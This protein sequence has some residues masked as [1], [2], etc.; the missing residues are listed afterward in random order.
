MKTWWNT[1]GRQDP[2]V[3]TGTRT[4]AWPL[5]LLAAVLLVAL[6]A[7]PARAADPPAQHTLGAAH[8]ERLTFN[9]HW[10][11]VPAG[12]GT[13]AFDR[14][15]EQDFVLTATL[16]SAGAVDLFFKVEDVVTARGVVDARGLS[17]RHYLKTQLEGRLRRRSECTFDRQADRVTCQVNQEA[18]EIIEGIAG[19][20]NDPITTLYLIRAHLDFAPGATL[21]IPLLDGKKWYMARV[22][23]G[24]PERKFTPLGWFDVIPVHPQLKTSQLFRHRGGITVWLTNDDRR[25]PVRVETKVR[26]GAVAAD[27]VGYADGRGGRATLHEQPKP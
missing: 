21:Y 15:G 6:L 4:A 8:G 18:P 25:M 10:Q 19:N 5:A 3:R 26:I 2:W 17:S 13:L 22:D 20:V 14:A 9:I 16:N 24:Q 23:I 27:L 11:G 1:A 7:G 12:R